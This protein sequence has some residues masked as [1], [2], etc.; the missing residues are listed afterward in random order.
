MTIILTGD[1]LDVLKGLE[2]ASVQ[3]CVTSPPYWGLRDY[4]IPGRVWGGDPG[5]VHEWGAEIDRHATN[6]T[7]KRRWNHARN[8]RGEVQPI[9]KRPGWKRQHVK[10]GSFCACGAWFGVLGLEP[11]LDLYVA[12]TVEVFR[13]VRRILKN[14]GTLWL[15]LGDSYAT[16]G[17]KANTP[18]GGYRGAHDGD[19]KRPKWAGPFQQPNRMPQPGLK[20]KDLCMI[21]ARVALA[22]QADGWWL[23]SEIVWNKTNPMP[24]SIK[25]R[26]TKSHEMLYLLTKAATY[27]YDADA[28]KERC[29]ADTHARYARG[30]GDTHKWAD[31]GPGR[32]TIATNK[33][34]SLFYRAPGVNPKCVAPG[35]GIKQNSS[36]SAAVK[37]IVE[38]RNKRTVW[39]LP[40]R[41]YKGSHFAT[42][43][44]KLIEPC[45]LAG[46]R[47]GDVV[48]DPFGGAFTTAMVAQEHGRDSIMIE[49]NPAYVKL[50]SARLGP[51]PL[52]K[53]H[54]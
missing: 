25:D 12:H 21:P 16:G 20:P 28:I 52:L 9:D 24:E 19:K 51:P 15:N 34:G 23:R 48:L 4:Q 37:D 54:A 50:G 47:P 43:P 26:P 10:Q 17:G 14:D 11:T 30:R 22:L 46:S 53:R 2:Q 42:F 6:H 1:C 7:D 5:H 49:L 29:Q 3:T 38:F 36:F 18:G 33:P 8:G 35:R 13:E 39:T 45:I 31:G 27:Y 44:P 41:P 32:Q 40:T